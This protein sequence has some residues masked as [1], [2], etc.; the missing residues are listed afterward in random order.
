MSDP[1]MGTL[2]SVKHGKSSSSKVYLYASWMLWRRVII[3]YNLLVHTLRLHYIWQTLGNN[4]P[5]IGRMII[6]LKDH[7]TKGNLGQPDGTHWTT[8]G[9]DALYRMA[10]NKLYKLPLQP[11]FKGV[12]WYNGIVP[13]DAPK[14]GND[15]IWQSMSYQLYRLLPAHLPVTAWSVNSANGARSLS[16]GQ[17][18]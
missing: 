3:R 11:T 13:I 10:I 18:S 14:F 1:L 9:I 6:F 16:R 5:R 12:S 2:E 8:E 7:G 17:L 4:A 15:F